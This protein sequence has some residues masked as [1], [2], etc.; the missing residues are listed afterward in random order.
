MTG[1]DCQ[2]GENV[3]YLAN[4][5]AVCDRVRCLCVFVARF[6]VVADERWAQGLDHQVVVVESCDDDASIDA[7]DRSGDVRGRHLIEW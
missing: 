4:G 7:V 3:I 5:L 6:E 1:C 2:Y